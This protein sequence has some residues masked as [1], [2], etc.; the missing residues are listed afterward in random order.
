MV[1]SLHMYPATHVAALY[2]YGVCSAPKWTITPFVEDG[3]DG[4]EVCLWCRSSLPQRPLRTRYYHLRSLVSDFVIAE[5]RQG[6]SRDTEQYPGADQWPR[7]SRASAVDARCG[8]RGDGSAVVSASAGHHR[9][10]EPRGTD[11]HLLGCQV[12]HHSSLTTYPES[13]WISRTKFKMTK[14]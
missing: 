3:P 11:Q 6:G 9:A 1:N 7:F 13:P 14:G 10:L 5:S 8:T 2:S 12:C 4:L